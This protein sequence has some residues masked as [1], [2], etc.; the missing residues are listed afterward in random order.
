MR[1]AKVRAFKRRSDSILTL[2]CLVGCDFEGHHIVLTTFTGQL[3]GT[4][5]MNVANHFQLTSHIRI[6]SVDYTIV[7]ILIMKRNPP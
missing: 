7:E 1:S 4:R 2:A 5:A 6:L 3:G